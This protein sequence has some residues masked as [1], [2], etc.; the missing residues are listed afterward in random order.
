MKKRILALLLAVMFI[1]GATSIPAGASNAD[2]NFEIHLTSPSAV[3]SSTYAARIK[4]NSTSAYV[5][6]RTR[7]G[8]LAASGPAEFEV[9]IWGKRYETAP[10]VDCTT[11]TWDHQARTPANIRF[12]EEGFVRQDVY[13]IYGF[14]SFAQ[15]YGRMISQ[16]GIAYGCWSPDSVG[17]YPYLNDIA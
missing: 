10:F 15:I 9:Q 14:N 4:D 7:V 2:S 1:V 8:G 6:Y 3:A 13:E 17:S 5:N 11:V 12:G 16:S